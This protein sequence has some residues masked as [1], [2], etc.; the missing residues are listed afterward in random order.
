MKNSVSMTQVAATITDA[1]NIPAPKEAA[2]PMP[3]VRMLFEKHK[4]EKAQKLLIYNPDAMGM[5]LFQKYTDLFAPVLKHTEVGV[6]V[7]SVLPS[8]T[9]VNF[10]SM[11]TGVEPAVHGIE[12]YKKVLIKQESLF[13]CIEKSDLR[14]VYIATEDSSMSIIFQERNIDYIIVP[15]DEDVNEKAKE[16]IE[17]DLY[18]VYLVYNLEYDD[19]IH[20]THPESELSLSA[21]KHHINAFDTLCDLCEEKWKNYDSLVCWMTDH[22]IHKNEEGHGVHGADIEE[23]V[24]VMHFFGAWKGTTDAE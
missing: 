1:L 20:L 24:N 16:L 6:P 15:K 3:F 9:P 4:M 14:I 12:T 19:C 22:G 8:V 5:W 10:G 13:D 7:R 18:D 2:A 23:D 17:A 11:Y 21:M